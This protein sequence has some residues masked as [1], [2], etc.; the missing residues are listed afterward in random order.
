V[1]GLSG[2]AVLP[3]IYGYFADH[4]GTHAAYWVLMPCYIYLVFYA[5][6]GYRIRS[7]TAKPVASHP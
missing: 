4:F 6:Y 7:W 1:M 3:L 2:S 5:F